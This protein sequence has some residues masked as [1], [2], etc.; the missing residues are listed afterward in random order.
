M[1][2]SDEFVFR[3]EMVSAER[4]EIVGSNDRIN[5]SIDY[6]M[7]LRVDGRLRR[8]RREITSVFTFY[9]LTEPRETDNAS[10]HLCL[11]KYNVYC[12]SEFLQACK[13]G[14]ERII[15]GIEAYDVEPGTRY[16]NIFGRSGVRRR[17][18][19]LCSVG[20]WVY[21]SAWNRLGRNRFKRF[22]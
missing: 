11:N 16:G 8:Y 12:C 5:Q 6:I 3:V 14:V 10:D 20:F 19:L 9:F 13:V 1:N 17:R 4:D 2:E 18:K 22:E 21:C 15:E 7:I